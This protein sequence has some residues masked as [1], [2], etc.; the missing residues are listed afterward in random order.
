MSGFDRA[1]LEFAATA[2]AL[3]A[4]AIHDAGIEHTLGV[5]LMHSLLDMA[6][7]HANL[8]NSEDAR[9]TVKSIRQCLPAGA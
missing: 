4:R 8:E 5:G 6:E 2:A 9:S 3:N 7:G 1:L